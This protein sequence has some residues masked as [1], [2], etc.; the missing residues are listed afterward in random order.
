MKL[1]DLRR[2]V[3]I[4]DE[5][6]HALRELRSAES[7]PRADR[8]DFMPSPLEAYCLGADG[9]KNAIE[10]TPELVGPL[11]KVM[12]DRVGEINALLTLVDENIRPHSIDE[13]LEKFDKVEGAKR[14]L[15]YSDLTD[16]GLLATKCAPRGLASEMVLF[17]KGHPILVGFSTACEEYVLRG[18][19]ELLKVEEKI[20]DVE[21]KTIRTDGL[22]AIDNLVMDKTLFEAVN[23]SAP[24]SWVKVGIVK[25]EVVIEIPLTGTYRPGDSC[26]VGWDSFHARLIAQSMLQAAN[27]IEG[28]DTGD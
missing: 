18:E 24:P 22:P 5:L 26:G 19:E 15:S 7:P 4:R 14:A 2:L 23:P 12:A 17:E 27:E 28:V 3:R 1:E 8:K 16:M 13:V 10:V 9:S 11:R 6:N 20:V 21:E 25:K